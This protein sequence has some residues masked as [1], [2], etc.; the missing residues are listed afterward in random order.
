MRSFSDAIVHFKR[1][2]PLRLKDY[3]SGRVQCRGAG[4][5]WQGNDRSGQ[6][7]R[8]DDLLFSSAA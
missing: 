3:S 6:F 4:G 8:A 2:S 7:F 5:A 1:W